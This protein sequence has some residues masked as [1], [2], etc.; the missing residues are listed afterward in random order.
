MK[1]GYSNTLLWNKLYL[2]LCIYV[3]IGINTSYLL[4]LTVTLK[5]IYYIQSMINF[6]FL[7]LFVVVVDHF[8]VL[9]VNSGHTF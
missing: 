3:C 2:T 7:F 1:C 9:V 4:T 5:L 6:T 8:N